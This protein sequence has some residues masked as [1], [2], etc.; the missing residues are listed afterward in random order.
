MPDALTCPKCSHDMIRESFEGILID[1]CGGCS[2][3]WFDLLEHEDLKDVKGSEAIDAGAK[4]ALVSDKSRRLDCPR[5][6]ARMVSIHDQDQ[7]HVVYEKCGS[8]SGVF[9]DAGEFTDYKNFTLAE[10]LKYWAQ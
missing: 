7:P 1:R 5:C 4:D 6:S 10:R 9:F 3:I 8:C 2:G